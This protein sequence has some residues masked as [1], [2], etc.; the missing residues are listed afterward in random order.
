MPMPTSPPGDEFAVVKFAGVG[1]GRAAV[2]DFKETFIFGF[3]HQEVNVNTVV[4]EMGEDQFPLV[5][6][7]DVEGVSSLRIGPRPNIVSISTIGEGHEVDRI[8][9]LV[10]DVVR[11]ADDAPTVVAVLI[12]PTRIPLAPVVPVRA[13]VV[14]LIAAKRGELRSWSEI[15]SAIEAIEGEEVFRAAGAAHQKIT[16]RA[17]ELHVVFTDILKAAVTA[18][19]GFVGRYEGRVYGE[20]IRGSFEMRGFSGRRVDRNLRS[21]EELGLIVPFSGAIGS[22]P[23]AP[24]VAGS[25]VRGAGGAVAGEEAGHF[26]VVVTLAEGDGES[27]VPERCRIVFETFRTLEGDGEGVPNCGFTG[28]LAGR[29]RQ[30]DSEEEK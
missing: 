24:L 14:E 13:V 4:L 10:G 17:G 21:G 25:G 16:S 15:V 5:E 29:Y 11:C 12:G 28:D 30:G 6:F 22:K 27:V 7:A 23:N 1:E 8:E 2:F 20:G 19:V 18:K 9:P 26:V 3:G